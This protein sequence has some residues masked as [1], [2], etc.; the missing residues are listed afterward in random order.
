MPVPGVPRVPRVPGAVRPP[1]RASAVLGAPAAR[2]LALH[3]AGRAGPCWEPRGTE[4]SNPQAKAVRAPEELTGQFQPVLGVV[5]PENRGTAPRALSYSTLKSHEKK[6]RR[7]G[8]AAARRR[9]WSSQGGRVAEAG[10]AGQ[11]G[12]ATARY[13]ST[14]P[15]LGDAGQVGGVPREKELWGLP[16]E[17]PGVPRQVAGDAWGFLGFLGAL[18][19][20]WGEGAGG[21]RS[22][23]PAA[24]QS[25]VSAGDKPLPVLWSP[26]GLRGQSFPQWAYILGAPGVSSDP[27]SVNSSSSH[28]SSP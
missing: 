19:W 5:P 14:R 3:S 9:H 27:L 22:C 7:R 16:S 10:T 21:S 11:A 12:R 15:A 4:N 26:P 8:R 20:A 23:A 13:P 2:A 17:G 1:S 18:V 28:C 6:A 25:S 24:P